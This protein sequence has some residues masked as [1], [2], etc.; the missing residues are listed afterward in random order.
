MHPIL[1]NLG[2]LVV[3]SWHFFFVLGAMAGY[4][5]YC[6]LARFSASPPDETQR[7]HLFMATYISGYFGARIASIIIENSEVT[8]LG[9][10]LSELFRLGPMTFYGGMFGG[11]LAGIIFLQVKRLDL[12]SSIDMSVPA[13]MLGLGFG[14]I[15]CFL[16]GDDF[17]RPV[18]AIGDSVP[19]FAVNFPVLNDDVWRYPVQLMESATA[20]FLA[21]LGY[22]LIRTG[23]KSNAGRSGAIIAISYAVSRL[24]LETFRGDD[25]GSLLT[26]AASPSQ[27]LSLMLIAVSILFW[28]VEVRGRKAKFQDRI[29]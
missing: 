23:G 25:R 22:H 9:S 18:E 27:V 8:G 2:F 21:Y 5:Y 3:S 1:I 11:L 26:D 14:R 12:A 16:N 28:L 29:F 7:A 6:Y 19:W 24:V 20:F 13:I 4:F 15:G 17:G 10:W